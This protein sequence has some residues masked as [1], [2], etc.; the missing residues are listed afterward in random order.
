MTS[1]SHQAHSSSKLI[2]GQPESKCHLY[3][4]GE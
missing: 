1:L 4:E 2:S 3:E